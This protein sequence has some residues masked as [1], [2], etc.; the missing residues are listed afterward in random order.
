MYHMMGVPLQEE[1][2]ERGLGK[3][4]KNRDASPSPL[5]V[6]MFNTCERFVKHSSTEILWR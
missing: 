5:N 1:I 2:H 4:G 6:S 3:L